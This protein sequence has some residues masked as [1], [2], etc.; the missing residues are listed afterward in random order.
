MSNALEQGYQF[1]IGRG[2]SPAQAAGI[3]GNLVG[4]SQLNI[5]AVGDRGKAF[6]IAQWHPDRQANF[7]KAFG[8]D[9]R[10]STY[11]E[12]L[13]FVDWELR[14]TETIAGKA[15]RAAKNVR[16]ATR[17]FMSKYERPANN[18]SYGVRLSAAKKALKAGHTGSGW[19]W[20]DPLGS[21]GYGAE[22][23]YADI[24]GEGSGDEL[25]GPSNAFGIGT[26]LDSDLAKRIVAVIVGI[27]LVGLAIAAV[28][29]TTDATKTVINAVK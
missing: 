26:I 11:S 12:Q 15:L 7:R 8:K 25:F 22:D 23:A 20:K 16:S 5:R 14:N 17:I 13:A 28:T 2:Y 21:F 29:L 6:G 18:S 3:M 4:E 9:I 24:F 27:V 1:F 19:D 10:Q